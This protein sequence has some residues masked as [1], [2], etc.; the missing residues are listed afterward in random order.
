LP[1]MVLMLWRIWK[2]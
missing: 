1:K 2:S